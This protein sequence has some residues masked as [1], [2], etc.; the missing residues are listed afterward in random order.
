MTR[1]VLII[2]RRLT[3]YRVPLFEALRERL[4][5]HGVRLQVAYGTP[6]ASEAARDD[7]GVL[8][9][10]VKTSCSY[11]VPLAPHLV[12]QQIPRR[13]IAEQ[14]LI[15]VAHENMLLLNYL[16]LFGR[17]PPKVRLAFWGHGANF[18]AKAPNGLRERL[19]SW[20][21][22]RADWWF[23]YTSRSVERVAESGF[24]V[25]R[26]T[27]LN[28]AL[29]ASP[30]RAWLAGIT[31][32]EK[33][34]LLGELGLAGGRVG[35][36]LG[37][38]SR[39][40]RL[41]FLFEAA[42]RLRRRFPDFELLVIGDGPQRA[43][44]RE[45]AG[46]R[47][48]CRWVGARHG[49][50]KALYLSLGDVM[51][52][53]GMVGLNILD[54]FACGLPLL[55]TDC[56]I[57]SPE[58]AYLESGS[59]GVMTPDSP[60]AYGDAVAG[61]LLDDP[62]RR[63][64]AGRCLRDAEKYSLENMV[65]NFC[66]GILQAIPPR[67]NPAPVHVVVIWQRFLSYHAARL[68]RLN[69]RLAPLGY[70]LSAIEVASQDGSYGFAELRPGE[71]F[72]HHCLFPG[73]SYHDHTVAEIH[74]SVQAKLSGLQ[75][76]IV[77]APAT[78]FPEG[79]A[80]DAY[81]LASGCRRVMMD[82]AWEHTDRRGPLTRLMKR[83]I[84]RNIDGVFIPAPSH[85]PY[86]LGLGFPAERVLHGVDVVDNDFFASAADRARTA[87]AAIREE[88]RLPADYFLFVGRFLPRKGLETLFAAY[89]QYRAAA[90]ETPWGLVLVGDGPHLEAVHGM[91]AG[92]PGVQLAGVARGEELCR[93]Y[94]LARALIVPSVLDP[95]GLVVNEGMAAGLPVLVSS[96]CGAARTLVREGENG[97]TFGPDRVDCLARLM[98][99]LARLP[100]RERARMGARSRE[101]IADWSL[102]RF[103]DGVIGALALSRRKGGGP[104]A[105][106]ATRLWKGR[107]SV[108]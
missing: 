32:E 91:A 77:F 88:K 100:E 35:V 72:A 94:A 97:W 80:A 37:S 52:N 49:R 33:R 59:N 18:Q 44:V 55:T 54:S 85:A 40:K 67:S 71:G 39:E 98:R 31:A 2:Q 26:I 108:N 62:L 29:D 7:A 78:P 17:R 6:T 15:V 16:L 106:L 102:D 101:M 61:L 57:H 83:L 19:K 21:A 47:P 41:P 69:A 96:G 22:R 64:I 27:C 46:K 76:D 1:R 105:N 84:H 14:D 28:N 56:G 53:P 38:L 60:A 10:G 25:E 103:A 66:T 34:T 4:A 93:Y 90:T 87:E 13:I 82:D 95:W 50:E 99:R 3:E 24:P 23:A 5:A 51:L 107:V 89:D 68:R 9:W 11:P 36:F 81:R 70:R 79:M 63:E 45:L 30:L 48:W 74:G 75:P 92:I 8:A 43:L 86:Y 20:T 58:I 65:A 12:W 104:L 73:S 42:D